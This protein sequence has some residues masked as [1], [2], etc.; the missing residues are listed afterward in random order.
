[1]KLDAFRRVAGRMFGEIPGEYRAGVRSLL[2]EPDVEP[3][4]EIEGVYTLGECRTEEWPSPYGGGSDVASDLVLYHGSFG[5]LAEGEADFDWEAELWETVLHE[6]LHHREAAAGT[7][8][9][10]LFDWVT[11]Q[12]ARRHAG[13]PFAP[14]YIRLV[15]ADEDGVRR[16]DSELF[17]EGEPRGAGAGGGD[18]AADRGGEDDV[19]FRWRGSP[20]A[21]R[22]PASGAWIYVRVTNLAGGR[23][24]VVVRRPP[25]LWR[26]LLGEEGEATQA[27]ARARPAAT[28]RDAPSG[29]RERAT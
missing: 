13:L 16:L 4:P 15:P 19:V 21:V 25:S 12:N 29:T 6:L 18:G 3:H 2:V 10:E 22:S 20:Y 17:V 14:D 24:W 27:E 28:G 1:M 8:S 23:L 26:R 11:E 5:A 7:A 9:L